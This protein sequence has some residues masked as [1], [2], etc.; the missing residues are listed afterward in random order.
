[1]AEKGDKWGAQ[2]R[3]TDPNRDGRFGLLASAPGENA[4]D[5]FVWVLSAG[6]GGITASGSWT[7][8][9]D[10]LGAPSVAAAFGA[11]IDE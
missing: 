8:G 6:T 11:A 7:Y 10:T 2:V 9:A 3:L 4:G 5:G 1:M